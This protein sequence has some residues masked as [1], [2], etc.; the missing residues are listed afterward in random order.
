MLL[1]Y[2]RSTLGVYEGL[3]YKYEHGL[4]PYESS[5]YEIRNVSFSD[6]QFGRKKSDVLAQYGVDNNRGKII[7]HIFHANATVRANL[8]VVAEKESPRYFALYRGT[9]G[10]E[11][12][13]LPTLYVNDYVSK[14]F[15]IELAVDKG[16]LGPP[17]SA[18]LIAWESIPSQLSPTEL[19]EEVPRC[20][21]YIENICLVGGVGLGERSTAVQGAY[22][23]KR[24]RH[25]IFI[26]MSENRDICIATFVIAALLKLVVNI[27]SGVFNRGASV[28]PIDD[29]S[30][31]E[32]DPLVEKD[33]DNNSF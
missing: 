29:D 13:E 30:E 24:T 31:D 12:Y 16:N 9:A 8:L 3:Y 17:E 32:R 1:T 23:E 21:G 25:N 7:G 18:C 28:R 10:K 15:A 11:Y 26:W 33:K 6:S 14:F 5:V 22:Y 4:I 27:V 19:C 2:F 20:A